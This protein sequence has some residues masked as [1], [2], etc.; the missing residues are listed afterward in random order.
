M[1]LFRGVC[2]RFGRCIEQFK[3]TPNLPGASLNRQGVLIPKS[4]GLF[5][6]NGLIQRSYFKYFQFE[7]S[8]PSR[9]PCTHAL[10]ISPQFY[11]S[12]M[13]KSSM[14]LEGSLMAITHPLTHLILINIF[15][16][17]GLNILFLQPPLLSIIFVPSNFYSYVCE[18]LWGYWKGVHFCLNNVGVTQHGCRRWFIVHCEQEFL[19]GFKNGMLLC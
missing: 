4:Q 8:C 5:T 3:F 17:V 14:S 19:P 10:A 2:I 13:T 12:W 16:K 6:A 11:C 1:Y 7:I 9:V 15:I 18:V